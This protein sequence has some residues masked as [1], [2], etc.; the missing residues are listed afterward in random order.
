LPASPVT[1][2]MVNT[3]TTTTAEVAHLL[4]IEG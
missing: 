4:L 3:M 2:L 1:S